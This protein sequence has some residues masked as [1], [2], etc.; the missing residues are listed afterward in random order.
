[1]AQSLDASAGGAAV[2]ALAAA[3]GSLATA[4]A[5]GVRGSHFHDYK[6]D[7]RAASLFRYT[8]CAG[9]RALTN[10]Q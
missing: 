5:F 9:G 8:L 10:C 2:F 7:T 1:M 4:L 6:L 3:F